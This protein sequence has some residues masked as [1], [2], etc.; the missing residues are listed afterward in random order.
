[1]FNGHV[2]KN[3][4]I[5]ILFYFINFKIKTITIPNEFE[6]WALYKYLRFALGF[7]MEP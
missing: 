7:S 3:I 6:K 4:L 2:R 1:M 5:I